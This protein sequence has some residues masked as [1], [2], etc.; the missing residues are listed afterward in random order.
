MSIM[1]VG[2][3]VAFLAVMLSIAYGAYQLSDT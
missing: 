2:I 1:S 3:V